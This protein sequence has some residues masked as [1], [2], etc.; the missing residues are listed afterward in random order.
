[1]E[2]ILLNYISLVDTYPELEAV[3]GVAIEKD[4]EIV[5]D[6]FKKKPAEEINEE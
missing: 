4:M 5:Y 2:K 1:M 3:F 6:N